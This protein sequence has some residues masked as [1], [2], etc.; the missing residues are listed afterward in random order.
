M[1]KTQI[2]VLTLVH[3]NAETCRSFYMCYVCCTVFQSAFVGKYIY[4]K[5][6]P[7]SC[8]VLV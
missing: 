1:N 8:F 3:R 5:L 6:G 7:V 4:Y 2:S